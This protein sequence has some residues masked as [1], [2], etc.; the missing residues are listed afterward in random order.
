M[1]A[2][3]RAVKKIVPYDS[4]RY[5]ALSCLRHFP[6]FIRDVWCGYVAWPVM[7]RLRA[8]HVRP[9]YSE[10]SERLEALKGKYEGQRC[11]IVATGPSLTIQDVEALKDERTFGLN[12]LYQIYEKTDW[13]PDFYCYGDYKLYNSNPISLSDKAKENIFVCQYM[14]KLAQTSGKIVPVWNNWLDHWYN[15]ASK[16]LRY[17]PDLLKGTYCCYT[18][19]N[20]AIDIAAY[21]GFREIYLLGADCNYTG[22]KQHAAGIED[23]QEDWAMREQSQKNMMLGYA[24]KKKCM[25][26]QGVRVYNCTRGGMLEVFPRKRLEEVLSA[27]RPG[28]GQ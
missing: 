12:R 20:A 23:V 21:L 4:K 13:R 11:F 14:T 22:S 2:L 15:H 7:S 6:S 26:E 1:D 18:V 10:Y 25:D 17:T 27:P 8:H 16:Q 28:V 3:T 9:F 24:F 5:I 19:A